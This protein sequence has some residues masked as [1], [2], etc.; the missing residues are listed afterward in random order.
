MPNPVAVTVE[1]QQL[2]LKKPL[3]QPRKIELPETLSSKANVVTLRNLIHYL[4]Q[5]EVD[6]FKERQE[7]R[8]LFRV[9]T[10]AQIEAGKNE[11][12][13]DPAEKNLQQVVNLEETV[14]TAIQAFEDGL[15]FVF[16]NEQQLNSLDETIQ[17]TA[18]GS[19]KFVRLVALAGG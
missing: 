15:Y 18:E 3:I 1:G 10:A 17:F 19:L 4:V 11:G 9:L 7:N 6:A 16:F 14:R 13:I 2:G 12:R 8:Q 5:L